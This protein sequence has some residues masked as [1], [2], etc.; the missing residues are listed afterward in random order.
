[1]NFWDD[2]I[3]NGLGETFT[4]YNVSFT[5]ALD[6]ILD[7]AAVNLGFIDWT[8]FGKYNAIPGFTSKMLVFMAAFLV[9]S[10]CFL[11][12]KKVRTVIRKG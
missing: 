2:F 4:D 7:N 11:G 8:G 1:M 10:L 6:F 5:D 12:Y 3:T 9:L